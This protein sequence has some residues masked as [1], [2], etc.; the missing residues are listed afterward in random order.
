MRI[1]LLVTKMK[2]QHIG[3][4]TDLERRC[5]NFLWVTEL[6]IFLHFCWAN[7]TFPVKIGSMTFSLGHIYQLWDLIKCHEHI[8]ACISH[9]LSAE[10]NIDL[11]F[12]LDE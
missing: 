5:H 11:A 7:L 4:Y 10:R 2:K 12:A 1:L 9:L 6:I 8:V 3:G